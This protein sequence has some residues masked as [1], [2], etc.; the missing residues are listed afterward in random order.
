MVG[1]LQGTSTRSHLDSGFEVW[2]WRGLGTTQALLTHPPVSIPDLP[3]GYFTPDQELLFR[4][5]LTGSQDSTEILYI[6]PLPRARSPQRN[7]VA[8]RVEESINNDRSLPILISHQMFE[9]AH[10][11]FC[12]RQASGWLSYTLVRRIC[13]V[14]L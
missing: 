14:D 1:E 7:A 4:R 6:E 11:L 10:G 2:C 5:N 8:V 13:C 3:Q 12:S 9:K